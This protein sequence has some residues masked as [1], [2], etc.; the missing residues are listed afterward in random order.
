[1][2]MAERKLFKIR[3]DRS[4]AKYI[5]IAFGNNSMKRKRWL[6]GSI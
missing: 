6:E 2:V 3:Q 1:M 5:D 4:A